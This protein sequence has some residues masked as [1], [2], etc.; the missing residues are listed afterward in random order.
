MNSNLIAFDQGELIPKKTRDKIIRAL[1]ALPIEVFE[2]EPT[3]NLKSYK[4]AKEIH[5]EYV[6]SQLKQTDVVRLF[7]CLRTTVFRLSRGLDSERYVA[8]YDSN[9][10]TLGIRDNK[11]GL[12]FLIS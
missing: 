4:P 10:R 11:E 12:V 1:K 7:G 3:L 5:A 8:V 9:D 6:I 2:G